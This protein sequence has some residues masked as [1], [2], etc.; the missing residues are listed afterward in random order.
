V[1]KI[2]DNRLLQTSQTYTSGQDLFLEMENGIQKLQG[3]IYIDNFL[4][5]IQISSSYPALQ[6]L[7]DEK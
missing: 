2:T 1:V 4:K 7:R 5:K 6:N 3:Q